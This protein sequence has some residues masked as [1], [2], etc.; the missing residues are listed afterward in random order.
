MRISDDNVIPRDD[1]LSQ[2]HDSIGDGTR[3]SNG[4]ADE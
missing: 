4:V 2:R 3:D 1:K